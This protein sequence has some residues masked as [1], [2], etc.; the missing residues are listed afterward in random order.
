M[1]HVDLD[2]LEHFVRCGKRPRFAR[3]DQRERL[4]VPILV[5]ARGAPGFV[6]DDQRPTAERDVVD[7]CLVARERWRGRPA[8]RGVAHPLL[9]HRDSVGERVGRDVGRRFDI[10]RVAMSQQRAA[11]TGET[12]KTATEATAVNT[13]AGAG[14]VRVRGS[15]TSAMAVRRRRELPEAEDERG[16]AGPLLGRLTVQVKLRVLDRIRCRLRTLRTSVVNNT[17]P[18]LAGICQYR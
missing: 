5:V 3:L 15:A 1:A 9:L 16:N 13:A 18:T 11:P 2:R 4:A 7:G 17:L 12:W 14:V 6:D 10:D 8:R